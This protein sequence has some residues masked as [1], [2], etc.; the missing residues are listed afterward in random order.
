MDMF[1]DRSEFRVLGRIFKGIDAWNS[2]SRLS[3]G[4]FWR[5]KG[6]GVS[7]LEVHLIVVEW[8]EVFVI[9]GEGDGSVVS[10]FNPVGDL[11]RGTLLAS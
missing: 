10:K 9:F 4:V 5:R 3:W 6:F 7:D 2:T 8:C 1:E 11:S